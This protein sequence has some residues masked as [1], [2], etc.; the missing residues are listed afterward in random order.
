MHILHISKHTHN[1]FNIHIYLNNIFLWL[2][3]VHICQQHLCTCFFSVFKHITL[4]FSICLHNSAEFRSF[5]KSR[6]IVIKMTVDK[7]RVKRHVKTCKDHLRN[8]KH[9]KCL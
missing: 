1:M 9:K 3:I 5:Q 8:N 4:Y 6:F 7:F 2:F